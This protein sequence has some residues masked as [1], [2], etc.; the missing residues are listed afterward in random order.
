DSLDGGI[1]VLINNAGSYGSTPD[2][3]GHV[4]TADWLRMFEVNTVAPLRVTAAL[5]PALR[6]GHH[7]KVVGLSSVKASIGRNHMGA[8]YQYRSTKAA[9]NAV[10][11]SLAV[12]LAADG[13]CVVAISPGWIYRG[14]YFGRGMSFDERLRRA[15]SYLAEF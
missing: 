5:L 10:L 8:A 1:D 9:M 4:D 14:E 6:R 15:R 12:D 2:R 13:I 3:L 7:P 11:R